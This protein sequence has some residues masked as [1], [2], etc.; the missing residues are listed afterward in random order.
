[1][2]I[3]ELSISQIKIDVP[4]NGNE[5]LEKVLKA[6]NSDREIKTLWR[7][8]NVN[9][10]E[11]LGY[12]DHGPTH[13]NIVANYALQIARIF[14]KKGVKMSIVKDFGLTNKHAEVVIFLA[15]L[16]HDLGMSIHRVN[17]E[18]FSLFIARDFLKKM[19]DFMPIE[20]RTVV[21]SETLHAIISHS[22]GSAG[23][24]ST[25][26]GGI[27]RIA[28]ALDMSKGRS[29]IPYKMGKIDIHS[30]SA[31]AIESVTVEEG[32]KDPVDINIVMTTEAGV[33][34]VDDFIEEK[35]EV[36]G[37]AKYIHVVSYLKD[38]G[39]TRVY[40]TYS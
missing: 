7:I 17:H 23:K 6:I 26:E 14:T 25:I 31:N 16:M 27:V 12:T 21:L 4:I 20:E 33:F 5:I 35:L 13:V 34:Q 22:H 8:M 39:K 38:K 15:S 3:D 19:L 10:I 9:A 24:T 40:K 18:M 2:K 1:M 11:R 32:T 30:V 28:D 36:S 37:L 29:R